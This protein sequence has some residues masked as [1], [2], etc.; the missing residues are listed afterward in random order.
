[1]SRNRV[2]QHLFLMS[3]KYGMRRNPK[4]TETQRAY[5]LEIIDRAHQEEVMMLKRRL[6]RLKKKMRI[7]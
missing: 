5:M 4:L 7:D 2:A 3:G 1:M 6:A